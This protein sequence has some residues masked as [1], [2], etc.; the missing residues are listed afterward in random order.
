M[1]ECLCVIPSWKKWSDGSIICQ[2]CGGD[3]NYDR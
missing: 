2:N 3:K 1:D